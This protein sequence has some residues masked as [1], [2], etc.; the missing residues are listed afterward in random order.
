[1]SDIT[2]GFDIM[3]KIIGV[4]ALAGVVA[5]GGAIYVGVDTYQESKTVAAL[6]ARAEDS[7]REKNTLTV[8]TMDKFKKSTACDAQ[9]PYGADFTAQ[10]P[11]NKVVRGHICSSP[12]RE[13]KVTF[14]P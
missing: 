7:L 13:S 10:G 2:A 6:K 5:I 3:L 8:I 1:M 11:D 14:K 9:H 4:A 12:D